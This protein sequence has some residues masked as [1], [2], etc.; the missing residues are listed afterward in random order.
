[1]PAVTAKVPG[2]GSSSL[3]FTLPNPTIDIESVYVDI[4]AS[5]AAGDVTAEITIRDQSGVVIARKQQGATV[6][7]GA[8]GSATWALRLAD[9]ATAAAGIEYDVHNS[10]TWLD[11]KTTGADPVSADGIRLH[12]TGDGNP[13]ELLSEG[14]FF[15]NDPN[16]WGTTVQSSTGSGGSADF[17]VIVDRDITEVAG[18]A[19]TISAATF[20]NLGSSDTTDITANGSGA[21]ALQLAATAGGIDVSIGAGKHLFIHGSGSLVILDASALPT[22]DPGVSGALWNSAGTLKVSP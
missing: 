4:D 2:N 20:L 17:N 21:N 16:G 5:A 14:G 9:D 12:A 13:I 8:S 18:R 11:V 7:A 22:A 6:P 1:M 3:S 10:G 19:V 15:L